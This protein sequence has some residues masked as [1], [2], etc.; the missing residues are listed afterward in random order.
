[1]LLC[2]PIDPTAMR[3]FTEYADSTAP[4]LKRPPGWL[5]WAAIGTSTMLMVLFVVLLSKMMQQTKLLNNLRDR[6]LGLENSRA[7]TNNTVIEDQLKILTQ[8][9]RSLEQESITNQ[10][11]KSQIGKLNAD[12]DAL[13]NRL[14]NLSLPPVQPSSTLRPATEIR[15]TNRSTPTTG[16]KRPPSVIPPPPLII[17]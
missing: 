17:P 8:R 10:A 15:G 1:M 11:L 5:C 2:Q 16:T 13:R 14:P 9:L 12:L 3:S 7:L 4:L 6:L